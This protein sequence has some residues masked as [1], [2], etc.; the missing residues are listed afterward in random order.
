M[1][2]LLLVLFCFVGFGA[3][4]A[5][6]QAGN[7]MDFDGVDDF[8]TLNSSN[9]VVPTTSSSP[10]TI[11]LWANPASVIDVFLVSKYSQFSSGAS[12]FAVRFSSNKFQV[13]GD[14]I[15]SLFSNATVS[16]GSWN[17]YAVVFAPGANATKLYINGELDNTGTL[18]YNT[19]DGGSPIL[20]GGTINPQPGN[21]YN[22]QLDEVRI[23]KIVFEIR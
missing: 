16:T 14:G 15:G 4:E 18:T 22:G 11:E 8:V 13:I 6:A 19:A 1:K 7:A 20:I 21:Y 10:I 12:N 2:K 17:H 9:I 23:W 5:N 3:F